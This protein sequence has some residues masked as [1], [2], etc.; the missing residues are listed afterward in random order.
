MPHRVLERPRYEWADGTNKSLPNFSQ[1][2]CTINNPNVCPANS[3]CLQSSNQPQSYVCCRNTEAP[4]VCPNNQFASLLSNGQ[5]ETCT[6][7]TATCSLVGGFYWILYDFIQ[8]SY[9][10]QFSTV[11]AQ[12]VCCGAQPSM[13]T[14]ADG[15]STYFQ[16]AGNPISIL[17]AFDNVY[18]SSMIVE[19]SKN[20]SAQ[21]IS[22]DAYPDF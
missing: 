10:C 22:R 1:I 14:C 19:N 9:T 6:G 8:P 11:L 3:N 12:Y 4:R 20:K 21:Q 16:V 15:R 17:S 2:F 5:L 18:E 13:A 7:T